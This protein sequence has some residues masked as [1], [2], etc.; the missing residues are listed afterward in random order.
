MGQKYILLSNIDLSAFF[1]N[2]EGEESK[3]WKSIGTTETDAFKGVFDGNN[4]KIYNIPEFESTNTRV[5]FFGY[6]NGGTIQN[7][8]F[9]YK[10]GTTLKST[11][12]VGGV[13]GRI[14]NGYVSNVSS[15]G[16]TVSNNGNNTNSYGGLVGSIANGTISNSSNYNTVSAK[17]MPAELLG[18]QRAPTQSL[19]AITLALL[20]RHRA[21]LELLV[22]L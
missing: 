8:G 9:I 7:C 3:K 20:K 12:D 18:M 19:D 17:I 21:L 10:D 13:V 1:D 6:L 16:A 15:S 22:N 2:I 14:V 4:Y 11:Q 5:G